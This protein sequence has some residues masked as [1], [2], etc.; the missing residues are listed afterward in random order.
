MP[1]ETSSSRRPIGLAIFLVVAGVLGWFASF[2]LTLERIETLIDPSYVPSCNISPLV[3]CGPNMASP[4]GALFG[5]PNPIIG[6]AAFVAPIVVGVAILAGA[7]FAKWF[8]VIFNLGFALALWF[9]IWLMIQSI[10]VLGTLCPYCM[11]VWSVVI[12]LF[13]YVM[14]YNVKEGNFGNRG[15]SREI[16]A[17]AYPWVWTLV[18][19]SYLA[20]VVMAQL[21]LDAITTILQT[22]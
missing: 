7:R 12:P 13:W 3:T 10:F 20:V 9:V 19:L 1:A 11:L 16:A 14:A 8:W 4:Q 6:V 2:D 18:L 5:F 21:R 15:A 17:M 22:L